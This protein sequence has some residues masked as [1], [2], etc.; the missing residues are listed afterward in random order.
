MSSPRTSRPKDA[1]PRPWALIA[2]FGLVTIVLYLL[3]FMTASGGFTPKLG[4]DLQGGTRVT[5]VPRGQP[6]DAAMNQAK[7]IISDRVNGLGVSGA[8]VVRDGSNIVLTVPGEDATGARDLGTTSKLTIRPVVQAVPMSDPT[9]LAPTP[10]TG[11]DQAKAQKAI[12]DAK[13]QRQAPTP[14]GL[15]QA[16]TSWKCPQTD[17][18]AGVDDPDQYLLA[19][20]E[21]QKYLLAPQP[22]IEGA[23]DGPGQYLDGE[24]IDR[25]SV[26]SG[27][28]QQQ[29][30]VEV[31]F[32]FVS[33]PVDATGAW[34]KL[35]QENMQKQVAILMDNQVISAPVIRGVTPPGSAT[36]ITGLENIDTAQTLASNLRFGALPISFEDPN[37]DNVPASLGQA[38]LNAGLL[39]GAVGL[40][41]ILLYS[42]LYYRAIGFLAFLSLIAALILTYGVL[43]LL[44]SW[45]GY[46]LDLA[47]IA[48]VIIGIG[49]TADSFVVYFE[50]VKDEIRE[51]HRFRSAVPRGWKTASRT[52]VTGNM[53]SI[54]AAVVLYVLAIGDVRGF[55][56]TLGLTTLMDIFVA[57]TVMW[58]LVYLASTKRVFSKP[59]MNGLGSMEHVRASAAAAGSSAQETPGGADRP[60]AENVDIP[61]AALGTQ[62]GEKGDDAR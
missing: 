11:G 19:C 7:S 39:A 21:G 10:D 51:G 16:I 41:L 8:E 45:I 42:L 28:N 33:S 1:R 18:L 56:F 15:Q 4:I 17:V 43:V 59:S 52:I 13:A 49:M 24:K 31:G 27:F 38:S 2:L 23:P 20:G 14:E 54:I 6:D 36:S 22:K 12:D 34:S 5:L 55:A 25:G 30:Q 3:A 61:G 53:V 46:T 60:S 37:V 62:A 57:F 9:D 58:P 26:N 29:G 35:T 40:V 32:R 50:R 44:G 48:G 47:G